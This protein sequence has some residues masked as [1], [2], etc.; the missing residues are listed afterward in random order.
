ML[1]TT[2]S[3]LL[4]YI[5]TIDF[6][7]QIRH[8]CLGQMLNQIG[9]W[10]GEHTLELSQ[11]YQDSGHLN[12]IPLIFLGLPFKWRVFHMKWR[13]EWCGIHSLL[14]LVTQFSWSSYICTHKLTLY[15]VSNDIWRCISVFPSLLSSGPTDFLV[16][17]PE[18]SISISSSILLNSHSWSFFPKTPFTP[19]FPV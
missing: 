4:T 11:A 19:L 9:C 16:T 1:L 10:N 6:L 13:L 12:D 5:Q 15:V 3:N 18:F 14:F 2:L 8:F 7:V 17:L